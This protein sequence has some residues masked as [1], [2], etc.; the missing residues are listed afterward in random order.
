MARFDFEGEGD[1]DLSFESG[2][3][4]KLTKKVGDEWLEGELAGMT[5]MFPL[6]FVEV[7]ED[8]P[9]DQSDAS[10][11]TVENKGMQKSHCC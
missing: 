4:I 8:L 5:G 3:V 10:A 1:T 7:L 11:A 9:E 2:D 6:A